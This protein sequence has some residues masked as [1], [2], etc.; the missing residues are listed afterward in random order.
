MQ[1]NLIMKDEILKSFFANFVSQY[2]LEEMDQ[3]QAFERFVN[4]NIISTLYPREIDFEDLSTG[5]SNDLALDGVAIVVNGNIIKNEEEIGFLRERNGTLDIIFALIQSKSSSKF[6]GDQVGNFIFGVKSFFDDKSSISEN[7]KIKHLRDIKEKIYQHSIDF[8]RNPELKLFFVTTGVWKEPEQIV[9]KVRRE[10]K[11]LDE[12]SLFRN[13]A[14]VEF[15]DAERLKSTYREISRKTVK[16]ISF[17]NHVALP[18]MP[19]DLNVRQSFIG[20]IPVKSYL[21]LIRNNDGKLSKGLFYDNVRDYQGSNKVNKE[22][23]ETL[24]SSM[25]QALLPLLNN[26]ITIIAKKVEKIGSKL[27]LTDFQIV[28]G[29][30]SSHVLFNNTSIISEDTHIVLKVIDTTDQD[31]TNNI[32]KATNRQTE[33]KDEAFESI[34]PF[35]KDLQE[36]Y[37]AMSSSVNPP[38]FYERRSKEYL[39]NPKVKSWQVITLASQVKTYVSTVLAQPQSTHRYFGELLDSNRGKLFAPQSNFNDYYLSSLMINRLESLLKINAI[40]KK[41]R[42]FKY[43]IIYLTYLMF[44]EKRTKDFDYKEI[45]ISASNKRH[46][47]SMFIHACKAIGKVLKNNPMSNKNAIRSRDFTQKI[48]RQISDI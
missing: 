29:C 9:G 40:Y 2:E 30:Q 5:G 22:I 31:V 25:N 16:E 38:I 12:R 45:I 21:E 23:N 24:K 17:N 34:K 3:D 39:G 42:P 1:R 4:F 14:E 36:F 7:D 10:L 41:Y 6:K 47:R 46:L 32:I 18:D 27:K 35:H 20:S 8:E 19:K 43:H 37:K 13:E 15:Y 48:Q 26:G 28:N 33:V 44:I 11:E